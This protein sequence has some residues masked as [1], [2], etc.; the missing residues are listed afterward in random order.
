MFDFT[1]LSFNDYTEQV[2]KRLANILGVF[3]RARPALTLEAENRVYAAMVLQI[4]DH[5]D[6]KCL[7]SGL[8]NDK[9]HVRALTEKCCWSIFF[10]YHTHTILY[11][12]NP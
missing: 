10:L 4:F 1:T 5:Y 9:V 11:S 8:G 6:V 12:S 2:R 3:S 7:E